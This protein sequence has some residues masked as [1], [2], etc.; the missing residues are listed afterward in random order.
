MDNAGSDD[1]NQSLFAYAP[2]SR[3]AAP[4]ARVWY[5]MQS[6]RPQGQERL[7]FMAHKR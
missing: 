1:Y 6:V 3:S 2:A 7:L 4:A 5:L